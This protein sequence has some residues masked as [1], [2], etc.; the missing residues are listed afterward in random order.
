M[1][2][3]EVYENS[4]YGEGRRWY[5]CGVGVGKRERMNIALEKS[6]S[7]TVSFRGSILEK[8][9]IFSEAFYFYKII[10]KLSTI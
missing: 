4:M 2:C 10:S 5:V 6:F 3:Q 9:F 7:I 1:H 8:G